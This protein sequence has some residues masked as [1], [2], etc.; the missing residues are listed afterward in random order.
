MSRFNDDFENHEPKTDDPWGY[1]E[2]PIEDDLTG[3]Y[4]EGVTKT[5][6]SNPAYNPKPASAPQPEQNGNVQNPFATMKKETG[7]PVP[8]GNNATKQSSP[9]KSAI[10]KALSNKQSKNGTQNSSDQ[11]EPTQKDNMVSLAKS[12]DVFLDQDR[13][14][15]VSI[16]NGSNIRDIEIQSSEYEVY[17]LQKY[18]DHYGSIPYDV[19]DAV[20]LS[21]SRAIINQK[22]YPVHTRFNFD[23]QR[24]LLDLCDGMGN[25]V[26]ADRNGWDVRQKGFNKF[27]QPKYMKPLPYPDRNGDL[28]DLLDCVSFDNHMDRVLVPVW[29]VGALASNLDRPILMISGTQG[30]GKTTTA[31]IIRSCIDPVNL[32]GL[33]APSTERDFAVTLRRQQVPSFD[34]LT[35]IKGEIQDLMARVVTG[36]AIERRKLY[37]D[38]ESHFVRFKRAMIL[39]GI[40]N[41]IT[42]DDLLDRTLSIQLRR[43]SNTE[44]RLKADILKRFEQK[45]ASIIGGILNTFVGA[46]NIQDSLELDELPRLADF[47][48]FGVAIAEYL[49]EQQ[50]FG[51]EMFA[52]A[53]N[54]SMR[55]SYQ[56][57]ADDDPLAFTVLDFLRELNKTKPQDKHCFKVSD[58]HKDLNKYAPTIDIDPKELP[59]SPSILSRKLKGVR[60]ALEHMG[61]DMTFSTSARVA[62]TVTF[63]I[64][65]SLGT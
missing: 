7:I 49:G 58:L 46:L 51:K 6:T 18:V 59:G 24:L 1:Q 44:R 26:Y 55:Q 60:Q 22:V 34:N 9:A 54:N 17:L 65:K 41:P 12:Q 27:R 20:K 14:P 19:K 50:G 5:P 30:S 21:R 8:F 56:Y 53:F 62:R 39:T 63:S 52:R 15:C 37:T 42:Q 47:Y 13:I 57:G 28:L 23:G 43:S 64:R 11:K 61:W 29:I 16:I 4:E 32:T 36:G 10:P 3:E 33:S 40:S 45:Q 38:D 25:I 2:D 48:H 35:F 31:D